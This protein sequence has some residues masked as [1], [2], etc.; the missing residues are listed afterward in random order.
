MYYNNLFIN[1]DGV[2]VGAMAT[3]AY[4][5]QSGGLE[6]SW[7][8]LGG[9]YDAE[10]SLHQ[11][12]NGRERGYLIVLR[13]RWRQ[14][15]IAFYTY[16]SSDEICAIVWEQYTDNPPTIET[17]KF[18]NRVYWNNKSYHVTHTVKYDEA[19]KMAGL[20]YTTMEEW[21]EDA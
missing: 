12:H 20:I 4:L 2:S 21:W 8:E 1:P 10:P 16:R 5:R 14:L 13:K 3:L 19:N 11:W 15:N 9:K 18:N 6:S 7:N 17:A